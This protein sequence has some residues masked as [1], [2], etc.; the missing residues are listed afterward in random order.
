MCKSD[1]NK[2][3]NDSSKKYYFL[4]IIQKKYLQTYIGLLHF[5]S[6]ITSL[7]VGNY[8]FIQHIAL[9]YNDINNI[10]T[11]TFHISTLFS[12]LT[13]LPFWNKVQSWQLA[14]TSLK[15][16]GLSASQMQNFNRGRGVICM[17]IS[18]IYPLLYHHFSHSL[19]QNEIFS[20]M[21]GMVVTSICIY[22]YIL[23][24]DYGKVLF[25]VYGASLLG[26]SLHLLWEGSLFN[27]QSNYPYAITFLEKEA[28]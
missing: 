21:V 13:L 19:L 10:I 28:M 2:T 16:K 22:Q 15:D 6:S 12:G 7:L 26:Y 24:R 11:T 3:H 9:G 4:G 14:T 5:L 8:L 23:I 1:S 25:V 27:L 20:R 18:P 17:I